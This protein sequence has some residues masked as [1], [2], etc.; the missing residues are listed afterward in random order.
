MRSLV[1]AIL[2]VVLDLYGVGGVA[3]VGGRGV[4]R[5]VAA[6]QTVVL[7]KEDVGAAEGILEVRH[8]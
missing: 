6:L 2:H 7:R 3:G 5:V 8:G 1:A 4:E